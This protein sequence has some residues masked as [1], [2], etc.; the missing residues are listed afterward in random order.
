[1]SGFLRRTASI[2]GL[3]VVALTLAF[4]IALRNGLWRTPAQSNLGPVEV[5][6][7]ATASGIALAA[8]T[9]PKP[10]EPGCQRHLTTFD[11]APVTMDLGG[12]IA[13]SV[14]V[15]SVEEAGPG[16]WRTA[17][18]KAPEAHAAGTDVMRLLRLDVAEAVGGEKPTDSVVV[19][20]PGGAIG[21][22]LFMVQ[23]FD[24]DFPRNQTYVFFLDERQDPTTSVK[25]VPR[26]LWVW[27][28]DGGS[29]LT[30][31]EGAVEMS[32]FESAVK[33]ATAPP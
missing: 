4:A 26:A 19:W 10:Q 33:V 8:P 1:M 29:V 7:G 16:R 6:A 2:L 21:C 30:P 31:N 27:P 25:G 11:E 15:A 12:R 14:L 28:V 23:G 20:V 13:T 17:D 9:E 18:D 5:G 3:L 24:V 32:T 22:D